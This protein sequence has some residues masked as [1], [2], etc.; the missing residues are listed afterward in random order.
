VCL[1]DAACVE[2]GAHE[3][4]LEV[5]LTSTLQSPQYVSAVSRFDLVILVR[6]SIH[7]LPL[8]AV[9]VALVTVPSENTVSLPS[10]AYTFN[11]A[12]CGMTAH[13]PMLAPGR[14]APLI[15]FLILALYILFACL[16]RMLPHLSFFQ[17]CY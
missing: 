1:L 11:S 5:V 4:L 12:D 15:R 10:A 16:C 3:G 9:P 2:V 6:V 8:C 7:Y 17:F 13:R 14:N